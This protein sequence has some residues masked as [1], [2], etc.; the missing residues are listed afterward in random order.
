MFGI[1]LP[2]PADRRVYDLTTWIILAPLY[3]T[4]FYVFWMAMLGFSLRFLPF[5][6]NV[7]TQEYLGDVFVRLMQIGRD[8]FVSSKEAFFNFGSL[9]ILT[10]IVR[11]LFDHVCLLSKT[12]RSLLCRMA[13]W[14]FIGHRRSS[15]LSCSTACS[16]GVMKAQTQ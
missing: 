8:I 12:L 5:L 2:N 1:F 13:V 14:S 10:G 6:N 3:G 16:F 4:A 11:S 7:E 9:F 15:S